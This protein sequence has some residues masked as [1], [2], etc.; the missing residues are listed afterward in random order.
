MVKSLILQE[1]SDN[2]SSKM[3][4]DL[5]SKVTFLNLIIVKNERVCVELDYIH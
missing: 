2:F 4:P 1:K 3:Y 5:C